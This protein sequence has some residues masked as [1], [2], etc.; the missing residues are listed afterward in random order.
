MTEPD[1]WADP[2]DLDA[3][4][5]WDS[6]TFTPEPWTPPPADDGEAAFWADQRAQTA[7]E[8]PMPPADTRAGWFERERRASLTVPCPDCRV[9][10]DEVCLDHGS[11]PPRPLAKFPAH[12][13]RSQLARKTPG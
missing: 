3:A 7:R 8:P 9:A 4:P 13:R 6:P 5:D 10:V 2:V 1:P 12:T 11:K